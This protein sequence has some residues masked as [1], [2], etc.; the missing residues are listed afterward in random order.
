MEHAELIR[1]LGKVEGR[2]E[3]IESELKRVAVLVMKQDAH[4]NQRLN[5]LER[6]EAKRTG[7]AAGAGAVAAAVMTGLAW[8]AGLFA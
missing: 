2:L 6:N 4:N 1:S 3:G 8:I 7:W 5:E